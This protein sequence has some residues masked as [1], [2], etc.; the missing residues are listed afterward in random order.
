MC[1]LFV[2]MTHNP[3]P[4]PPPTPFINGRIRFFK[5]GCKGG[6]G[7]LLLEMRGKP[8]M[9]VWFCNGGMGNF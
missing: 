8:R 5:N 4:P 2:Y 1:L 6:D 7:K 9:G 3:T